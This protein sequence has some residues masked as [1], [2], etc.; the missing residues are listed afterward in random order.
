MWLEQVTD[1]IT[2]NDME[3]GIKSLPE[4]GIVALDKI[5]DDTCNW[6]VVGYIGA[7]RRYESS[8]FVDIYLVDSEWRGSNIG[9][10]IFLALME[11][12][13]ACGISKYYATVDDYNKKAQDFYRRLG[14]PLV[15]KL[16]VDDTV[17]RIIPVLR[18]RLAGDLD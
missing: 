15:P 8:A 2:D 10:A 18:E 1:L 9:T 3:C 11:M 12:F 6:T 5:T 16:E 14:I 17:A 7:H 13:N 4:F